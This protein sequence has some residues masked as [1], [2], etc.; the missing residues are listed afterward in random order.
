MKMGHET[1]VKSRNSTCKQM[2][3]GEIPSTDGGKNAEQTSEGIRERAIQP[4]DDCG[5]EERG[6]WPQPFTC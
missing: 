1:G 2:D 6:D 5:I 3:R 4:P